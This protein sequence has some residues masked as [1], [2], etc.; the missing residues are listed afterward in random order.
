M[1]DTPDDHEPVTFDAGDL[2]AAVRLLRDERLRWI[3]SVANGAH[4]AQRHEVEQCRSALVESVE[5]QQP[6]VGKILK[7]AMLLDA[8]GLQPMDEQC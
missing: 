8:L 7:L 5:A 2:A 1:R 6:G 3:L 4:P